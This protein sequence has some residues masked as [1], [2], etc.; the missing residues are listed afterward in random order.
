MRWENK[1]A[2][3]YDSVQLLRG[4]SKDGLYSV[5][6]T[7]SKDDKDSIFYYV[8]FGAADKNYFYALRG[9]KDGQYSAA[10]IKQ[11]SVKPEKWYKN[12]EKYIYLDLVGGNYK[13]HTFFKENGETC[14]YVELVDYKSENNV[15]FTYNGKDGE[16]TLTFT[17]CLSRKDVNGN[18]TYFYVLIEE[19]RVIVVGVDGEGIVTEQIFYPC[20]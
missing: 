13:G 11:A 15:E 4:E 9:Q 3:Q 18:D 16:T 1:L 7:F 5:L 6:G 8:D 17:K 20:E 2:R 14:G 12:E 19:A 10:T